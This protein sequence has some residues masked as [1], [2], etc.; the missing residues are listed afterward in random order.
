MRFVF[1]YYQIIHWFVGTVSTSKQQNM[2]CTL[3]AAYAIVDIIQNLCQ[4]DGCGVQSTVPFD[5]FHLHSSSIKCMH[6]IV[7]NVRK[8]LNSVE[9]CTRTG[10]RVHVDSRSQ[11]YSIPIRVPL[12][13]SF[14]PRLLL[15]SY[16]IYIC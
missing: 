7:G 10:S 9:S 12:Y 6:F 8:Y 14:T 3:T 11:I 1:K 13:I 15:L 16:P 5:L 4:V 2:C